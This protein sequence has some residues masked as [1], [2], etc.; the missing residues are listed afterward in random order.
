MDD[1]PIEELR[2]QNPRHVRIPFGTVFQ[3]LGKRK[4]AT[5]RHAL[6]AR[7]GTECAPQTIIPADPDRAGKII[8]ARRVMM[9]LKKL[10]KAFDAAGAEIKRTRK[11]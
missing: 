1:L 6:A 7:H 11:T 4:N 2:P 3:S 5:P 8:A 10:R 9:G